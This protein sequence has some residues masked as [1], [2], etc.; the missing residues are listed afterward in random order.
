MSVR[1]KLFRSVRYSSATGRV[2]VATLS[3]RDSAMTV[4]FN[5]IGR[6]AVIGVVKAEH[7]G[8][9]ADKNSM[10]ESPANDINRL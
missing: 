4:M 10:P 9:I 3:V 2:Q 1:W 7:S 8:Q 6:Y 5:A